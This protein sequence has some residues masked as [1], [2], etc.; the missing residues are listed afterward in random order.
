MKIAVVGSG[1]AG[2]TAAWRLDKKH[3]VTLFEAADY[4]GGHTATVDVE[5]AGKSYAVDTGFIVFND[6]TYPHFIALLDELGVE[7][8]FS[9]MSFSLS[10]ERTGLEYNGTSLNSLFAQ[11]RNLANPRFLRMLT[12]ILRFNREAKAFAAEPPEDEAETHYT[13]QRFLTRG[14]YSPQFIEQYIL[15]MGRAIW[16][17]EQQAILDFPA[18]FFIDFFARHG[19][20][21][22][23]D[24]PVWRTVRGGS[25]EYVPA[26]A[27]CRTRCRSAPRP[28]PWSPLTMSSSRA[29]RTRHSTCWTTPLSRS[30]RSLAA[31]RSRRMKPYC[32]PMSRCCH[33]DPSPVPLG[34]IICLGSRRNLLRSPTT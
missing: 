22:V 23:S 17:A 34:T 12:D 14:R 13:L 1:I 5:W 21:N 26:S 33:A 11:R 29:M 32:T 8:Q 31:F 2:L 28:A 7:W 30:A 3:E 25:R 16:S 24:R 20:L 4:V 6:W 9:N 15:P 10:C 19:F 27:A 18:R